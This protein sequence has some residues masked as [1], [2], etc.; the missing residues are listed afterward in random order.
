M[1]NTPESFKDLNEIKNRFKQLQMDDNFAGI[2]KLFVRILKPNSQMEDQII[3]QKGKY[4]NIKKQI[5]SGIVTYDSAQV[6]INR[7]RVALQELVHELEEEDVQLEQMDSPEH[8]DRGE[9]PLSDLEREGLEKQAEILQRKLNYFRQQVAIISDTA[10]K[11][12][13]QIQL[14]EIEKELDEIKQK[15]GG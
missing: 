7:I 11:F 3:V 8:K 9:V 10:Q 13:L 6:S 15:L 12:S 5:R 4:Q 2:F 14:E 1:M